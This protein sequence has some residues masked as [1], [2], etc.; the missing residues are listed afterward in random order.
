LQGRKA[1]SEFERG[2]VE[3]EPGRVE[4]RGKKTISQ[5]RLH[6]AVPRPPIGSKALASGFERVVQ[7]H[8]LAVG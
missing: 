3:S 7:T 2:M 6:E 4:E 1:E 5:E 8:G